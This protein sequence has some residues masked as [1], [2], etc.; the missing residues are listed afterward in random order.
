MAKNASAGGCS[1]LA[2]GSLAKE[3]GLN[4]GSFGRSCPSRRRD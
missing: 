4:P 3:G 2:V 1:I